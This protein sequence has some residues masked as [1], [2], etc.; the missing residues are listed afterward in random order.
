MTKNDYFSIERTTVSISLSIYRICPS[1]YSSIHRSIH[2]PIYL[3][4][5]LSTYLPTYLPTYLSVC[6]S[7]YLSIYLSIY[8]PIN[9]SIIQSMESI[10]DHFIHVLIMYIYLLLSLASIL[11]NYTCILNRNTDTRFHLTARLLWLPSR[12]QYEG[13]L[14]P[15]TQTNYRDLNKVSPEPIV[16]MEI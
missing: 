15:M 14:R 9:L 7:V 8:L 12:F 2:L 10:I 11:P 6:L 3:S 13:L 16:I 4:V 1:I 5:C